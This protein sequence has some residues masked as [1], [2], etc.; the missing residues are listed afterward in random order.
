MKNRLLRALPRHKS[1]L[2]TVSG[3]PLYIV[4][5]SADEGAPSDAVEVF[6][7]PPAGLRAVRVDNERG[8]ELLFDGFGKNAL[9]F[10]RSTYSKQCECVL[11]PVGCDREEWVLFVETKYARDLAA[12]QKPEANY[13]C[14]M[15]EQ[16]KATVAYFR[17]RGIL[18]A[19]KVVRAIV[20]F[21]NLVQEFDSWVFP[22]R[23]P[24]G[25]LET[26]MDILRNDRILIRATN[27]VT[28]RSDRD[29]LL[30]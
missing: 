8:V 13:P 9:P 19:D 3:H 16:I 17:S 2:R 10:T 24:D 11:F 15:V 14:R 7:S 30:I 12:A 1:T 6:P 28:I 18:A 20:S 23:H 29:L 22:V 25:T 21:P 26:V 27:R 4:D 5:W